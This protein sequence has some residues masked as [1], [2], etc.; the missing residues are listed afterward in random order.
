MVAAYV[1]ELHR[2]FSTDRLDRYRPA[3]AD[4]LTMVVTYLWNVQLCEALYPSLCAL[5]LTLRNTIHLTLTAHFNNRAGWYDVPGLLQR[6]ESRQLTSV[7]SSI[8]AAGKPLLPGRVIAGVSFGFWTGLLSGLYGNSPKG[9]QLWMSPNSPLLAAAFPHAP[10]THQPYRSR[11]HDRFDVLRKLR[12][13]VFHYE[14]IYD[15]PVLLQKHADMIDA[16]G[17]VSPTIQASTVSLDRFPHVYRFGQR[18]IRRRLKQ[19]LG[20]S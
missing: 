18:H 1:R 11:I 17:W 6:D 4:D 8:Q 20:I 13:R 5:E 7:K 9:P 10:V 19:D 2:L 14:S 3:G 16:I 12:N 15:D